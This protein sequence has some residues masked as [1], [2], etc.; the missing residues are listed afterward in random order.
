M[1]NF[2]RFFI[3]MILSIKLAAIDFGVELAI[4]RYTPSEDL[5]ISSASYLGIRNNFY[6]NEN[7]A[8]QLKYDITNETNSTKIKRYSFGFRYQVT[9]LDKNFVPFFDLGVGKENGFGDIDFLQLTLG[10]KYFVTDKF[11][12]LGEANL[13]KMDSLSQNYSFGLGVGYDFYRKPITG[14]YSDKPVDEAVLKSLAKQKIDTT[15]DIFL[16]PY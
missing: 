10:S 5:N 13:M 1:G 15:E 9:D 12:L 3:V 14:R 16:S 2:Q 7:F 6:I 11:N 4:G 8:F